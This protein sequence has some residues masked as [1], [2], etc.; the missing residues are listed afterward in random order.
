MSEACKES[1]RHPSKKERDALEADRIEEEAVADD[2]RQREQEAR[3]QLKED[4]PLYRRLEEK[5]NELQARYRQLDL[6]KQLKLRKPI[7]IDP[8]TKAAMQEKAHEEQYQRRRALGEA[9]I[10]RGR[11]YS[12][13][14][15]EKWVKW[16]RRK[17]T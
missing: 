10:V 6:K 3:R 14:D 5:P 9:G 12:K 7:L 8:E 16:W 11:E 2:L 1:R 13:I 15:D 17:K 4:M